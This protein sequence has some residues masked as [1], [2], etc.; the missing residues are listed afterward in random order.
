LIAFLAFLTAFVHGQQ[1]PTS[2]AQVG[3]QP[4]VDGARINQH[5]IPVNHS[6]LYCAGF[7]SAKL[8]PRQHFVAG[9]LGTP[10]QSEFHDRD[11]IYLHGGGYEPGTRVSL[12]REM[13]DL[14][15]YSPFPA[16]RNLLLRTGQMYAE[17]GYARVLEIRGHDIAVAQVE[18][19]CKN[20][21]T[22]DLA[23]PFVAKPALSYRKRSSM[24]QFPATPSKVAGRIVAAREFDQYLASGSK[25][26]INVGIQNG[27]KVGDYFR[28]VRG[29][30]VQSL[31]SVDAAVFEQ[32]FGEDTQ[33]NPPRLPKKSLGELPKHVVGEAIVLG[34]TP[35]SATAMITFAME[36]IHVGDVIELETE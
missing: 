13:R 3:S 36:E 25:I 19:A 32:S 26:Y 12:V 34:T 22:G 11:L 28:V 14:N 20:V 15:S 27:V 5:D 35:G 16:A 33:K 30:E 8:L 2:P 6:D 4:V 24:D 18:F 9:G 23:V 1:T 31:D 29:Y 7:V 21:A 17:L 10:I